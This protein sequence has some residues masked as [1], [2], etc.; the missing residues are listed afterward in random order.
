MRKV[1][2]A[3]AIVI[4]LG[5]SGVAHGQSER[6]GSK[7]IPVFDSSQMI[8]LVEEG[9]TVSCSETDMW[10]Q[11]DL[12]IQFS[13]LNSAAPFPIEVVT[14]L[15]DGSCKSDADVLKVELKQVKGIPGR[16]V[17]KAYEEIQWGIT[18]EGSKYEEKYCNRRLKQSA[19]FDI[20]SHA[21]N[22]QLQA[23]QYSFLENLN[24]Y[25]CIAKYSDGK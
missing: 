5:I 3:G 10:G 22:K 4:V 23:H 25:E 2:L 18:S 19:Y 24:Y 9:T 16:I 21:R 20:E 7:T 14:A 11:S 13:K 12:D 1:K 15:Y 8:N 17:I 6:S